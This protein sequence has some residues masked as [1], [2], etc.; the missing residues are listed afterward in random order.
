[1]PSKQGL[2]VAYDGLL[3]PLGSSQ[4]LPYVLG[5]S[6]LGHPMAVLS[7]EKPRELAEPERVRTL[8]NR[9]ADAGVEWIRKTYH[10]APSLAATAYDIA[11]G[12]RVIRQRNPGLVHARSYVPG[13]MALQA[14]KSTDFRLL[15]D[16][17]G[18]WVDERI[19]AGGW[20]PGEAKVRWARRFEQRL[21]S[22]SDHIVHLTNAASG[23]VGRLGGADA[24]VSSTVIP[25]SVSLSRFRPARETAELRARLDLPTS[26]PLL[27]H[28]GTLGHRYLAAQTMAVA[29]AF[30]Q[31]G[32]AGFLVLSREVREIGDLAEAEGVPIHLRTVDHEAMPM[33]LAA[34]DAGI[35]LMK[36]GFATKAS[37]PTKVGEYL[38]CGLAVAATP[39][40]DV[41]QQL[42]DAPVGLVVEPGEDPEDTAHRILQAAALETRRDCARSIAKRYY[43]QEKAVRAY[44]RIYSE[45]EVPPCV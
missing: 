20:S 38:A 23:A 43:D 1:M 16:M 42:G 36:T 4:V 8:E 26:G 18:F 14:R 39:V 10:R 41:K 40:G 28:S 45:L 34:A 7:F 32:G 3:E 15:F 11:V 44:S 6:S 33:Y 24:D 27:V 5:L 31:Q 22:E 30:L 17:R 19:E 13:A 12:S 35:A 2:F 37:A 21:L 29:K 25:T 9:L